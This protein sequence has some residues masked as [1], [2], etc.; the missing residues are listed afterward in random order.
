MSVDLFLK[1]WLII[2]VAINLESFMSVAI[3]CKSLNELLQ[4]I[5]CKNCPCRLEF[6]SEYVEILRNK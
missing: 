5:F 3:S 4:F 2:S 1:N 6:E